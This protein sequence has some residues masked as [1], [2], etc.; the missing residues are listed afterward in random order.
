LRT[1]GL[2]SEPEVVVTIDEFAEMLDVPREAALVWLWAGM[3]CR[4]R[5]CYEMGEGF[6]L[7]PSWAFDWVSSLS[8][9]AAV[10]G[11]ERGRRALRL[12]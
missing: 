3:P 12:L 2:R 9:L 10:V 11:D 1:G 8:A 7:V 4:E 5:G 6:K